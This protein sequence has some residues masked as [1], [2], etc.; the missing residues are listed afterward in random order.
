M[1][2]MVVLDEGGSVSVH[3]RIKDMCKSARNR[4][5][6]TNQDICNKI[7]EHFGIEDFSVNTVNNFFSERSKATTIYTTGY[8]CAVLGI[9]IDAVFGIENELSTTEEMEFVKQLSELK[10]EARFNEQKIKYLEKAIA[11]KEE[12]LSQAHTALEHYRKESEANRK[13]VQPWVF[14]ATLTLLAI[15][16]VF[17]CIYLFVFDIENPSYGLFQQGLAAAAN[18]PGCSMISLLC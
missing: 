13:K 16:V 7:T 6:Y 8:I 1:S 3:T 17:I 18:L 14:F 12:R 4:L 15:A 5:G 10:N 2:E 9:S 11:E